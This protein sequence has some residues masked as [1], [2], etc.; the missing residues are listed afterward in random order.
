MFLFLF[1]LRLVSLRGTLNVAFNLAASQDAFKALIR[2]SRYDVHV[3]RIF[4]VVRT[5]GHSNAFLFNLSV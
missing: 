5:R 1:K 2:V 3:A 4:L